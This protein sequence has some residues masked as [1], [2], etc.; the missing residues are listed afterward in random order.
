[1]GFGISVA[2]MPFAAAVLRMTY[3]AAI[4]ASARRVISPNST[5]ISSWPEPPTSWW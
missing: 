1:M 4:V 5:S 2:V 3:F